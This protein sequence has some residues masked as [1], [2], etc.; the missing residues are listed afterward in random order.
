MTKKIKRYCTTF[1][2]CFIL[3][4]FLSGS[5][6]QNAGASSIRTRVAYGRSYLYLVDIAKYYS[7]ILAADS[8]KCEIRNKYARIGFI[9]D[10]R[11]GYMNGIKIHYLFPSL[12]PPSCPYVSATDYN[13]VID[14]ILRPYSVPKQVVR[15]IVLDPGHGGNDK[16]ASGRRYDEKNITLQIALKTKEILEK[17]GFLVYLTR[18]KDIALPLEERPAR[19]V[20]VGADIFVSIH[21]N[22]TKNNAIHGIETFCLTPEGAPSTSDKKPGGINRGN[23][24]NKNN[25]MLAYCM[26]SSLLNGTGALDRGIKHARFVVLRE[27]PCP[28][29]LI[30]TGFISNYSEELL[31]GNSAYQNKLAT[32]I[33]NGIIRYSDTLLGRR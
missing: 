14:P 20:S 22:A 18:T 2:S 9:F 10:K 15:R 11:D 29:I 33:A 3:L 23:K 12:G 26:H 31:L 27:A 7:M 4:F 16:G 24:F 25:F 19:C 1:F 13:M 32:S 5:D 17:K 30:E 8:E 21:C 28:A 6:A